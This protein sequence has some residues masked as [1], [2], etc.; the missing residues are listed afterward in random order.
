MKCPKFNVKNFNWQPIRFGVVG[1][2][3]NILL[4]FIYLFI[5]AIGGGHKVAMTLIFAL[6]AMQTFVI[7]RFWTFQHQGVIKSTFFR[8]LSVYFLSYALNLIAHIVFSDY[9]RINHQ[10]IQGFMVFVVAIILFILQ[11]HW[12][13]KI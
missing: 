2:I 1:V 7:N 12:V 6:G 8:Y 11:R 5:T 9:L 13:F 4:Y 10:I 3:S